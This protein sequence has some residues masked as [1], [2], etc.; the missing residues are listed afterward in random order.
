MMAVMKDP[1]IHLPLSSVVAGQ[2]AAIEP[3]PIKS[4][5]SF[6]AVDV[7]QNLFEVEVYS[8]SVWL[9]LKPQHQMEATQRSS[10][11]Q[12]IKTRL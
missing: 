12:F 1:V 8:I 7:K 9:S 10:V 11:L 5:E 4:N 3:N 2:A 6:Q